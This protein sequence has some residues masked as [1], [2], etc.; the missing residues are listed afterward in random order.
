M[1]T[2]GMTATESALVAL[3]PTIDPL[4]A[5]HRSR[6][7]SGAIRGVP[8]HVTVLYPF[9]P[10]ELLSAELV[11][12][13][14]QLLGEFPPFDTTFDRVD[15]FDDGLVYL[16]PTP[17]IPFRQMTA[18]V[19]ARWPDWPPYGGIHGAPTPHLT[20]GDLGTR[21]E[22][23]RAAEAIASALPLDAHSAAIHL[24]TGSQAPHSWRAHTVIEL[25][26]SS[27]TR[28]DDASRTL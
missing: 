7:D 8:A 26:R 10:P 17:D 15:W 2:G 24:Y 22:H 25:G 20:I 18:A 13:L 21:A 28:N 19:A 12:E 1:K 16:R 27:A 3:F 11:A 14:R 6:L 23:G 9:V 5:P 4:V